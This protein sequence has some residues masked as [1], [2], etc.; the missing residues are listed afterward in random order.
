[1]PAAAALVEGSPGDEE[2]GFAREAVA[3]LRVI[4]IGRD[5]PGPGFGIVVAEIAKYVPELALVGL[6]GLS[7][8]AFILVLT[9]TRPLLAGRRFEQDDQRGDIPDRLV[10]SEIG[11]ERT[12][13]P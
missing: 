13:E 4:R 7:V 11:F 1:M 3:P 10:V 5:H 12:R 8:L 6:G 9:R 2:E